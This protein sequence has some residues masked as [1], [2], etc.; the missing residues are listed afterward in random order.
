MAQYRAIFNNAYFK[1]LATATV[2]TL[3]LAAG[4]AQAATATPTLAETL[5]NTTAKAPAGDF[6]LSTTETISG[7]GGYMG[8]LTIAS[9]GS[10]SFDGSTTANTGHIHASGT[11][12]V[13]EG[14][15]LTVK[16]NSTSN[17]DHG[18]F[19]SYIDAGAGVFDDYPNSKFVVN[20]GTVINEHAQIQMNR[21]EL[22][23]AIVTVKTNCGNDSNSD[24]A[25]NAMIGAALA[26]DKAGNLISGTGVLNVT[27][28]SNITLD[29]GSQLFANVF[30]LTGGTINMK[31]ES[32]TNSAVIRGF[33]KGAQINIKGLDINAS[34]SGNYIGGNV[35]NLQ[36][37]DTQVSVEGNSELHLSG[38]INNAVNLES[39]LGLGTVNLDGAKISIAKGGNLVF[40]NEGTVFNANTG[41]ITNS[42]AMTFNNKTVNTTATLFDQ[43]VA[44][45]V[46]FTA[47]GSELNVSGNLD[48]N[49]NK[50][51][52][53]NGAL[54]AEKLVISG[55]KLTLNGDKVTLGTKYAADKLDINAKD[56]VVGTNFVQNRQT[57][58]VA[59][60]LAGSGSFTVSGIAA[61]AVLELQEGG[62]VSGINA[63]TVQGAD[64][65]KTGTLNVTGAWTGL[66]GAKLTL[67]SSGSANLKNASITLKDLEVNSAGL[68]SL[69]GS[70]L[71][72]KES[73]KN[74]VATTAAT[75]G[76]NA[77]NNSS[78]SVAYAKVTS[79]GAA[80]TTNIKNFK[81]DGTSKL[82]LT[83]A[84]DPADKL[85][86]TKVNELKNSFLGSDG[87]GLFQVEGFQATDK[88]LG[89]TDG[90]V[91]YTEASNNAGLA[92]AYSD[93]TVT[94]VDTTTAIASSND[95]G[96]AQ[97]KSGQ[98]SLNIGENGT[99]T[100]S[101]VNGKL[102]T[103]ASGAAASVR[104]DNANATL[105]IQG[106][107]TID[108]IAASGDN[109]GKVL[110]G[111]ALIVNK[112]VGESDSAKIAELNIQQNGSIQAKN[113]HVAVL[114]L[115]KGASLTLAGAETDGALSLSGASVVNGT[116]SAK[117]IT[118]ASG[119]LAIGGSIQATE[120]VKAADNVSI[121]GS[122]VADKLELTQASKNVFVGDE[123]SSG[124]LEVKNLVLNN[125]NL[126]LDPEYTQPTNF[127]AVTGE[128]INADEVISLG[129]NVGVGR[130]S[131]LAIGTSVDAAKNIVSR[132]GLQNG[133]AL[134]EAKGAVLVIDNTL[135]VDSGTA[136]VV[137]SKLDH[138]GLSAQITADKGASTSG[139]FVL[140]KDSVLV[141]TEGM[142]NYSSNAQKPVIEFKGNPTS[143]AKLTLEAGSTL[144]FDTALTAKDEVK[145]TNI[146]GAG[147]VVTTGATIQ[148]ANGL[149]TGAVDSATG[150][151]SF[152][153]KRDQAAK[154][155]YNTSA[156]VKDFVLDA[157][158]GKFG[159]ADDADAGIYYTLMNAGHD[160]GKAVE[161]TARL[162][163]YGGVVQGTDLA[164]KAANDAVVERMSR[165]NPN[166]SLV[167]A[168][169][170]QGGG[171]WLSPVY[172]SH[173][174]DSFD[175]D[176]VDYGVDG[177]LTGLVLGADSTTDS[178]VRVGGYFNFGSASFDGQGVGDQVSNDADYFGFGLYAGMTSGQF[179]L[180]ADAGFTQ[181][182]NDIEQSTGHK[183][184]S[185]VKADVDSTAVTLGLRGE[186]KLNVASVDV[187]P[188]LG[189]RYTRLNID[190]YDAKANGHTLATT[191][192]DTMQMF[193]IPFGVTV[194]KDI[195]AG[196][197]SIKPVFDLTL[198]ANAGDTDA[199]F[200]TT[201]IGGRSLD[202]TS[203]AF[204]SF[205]YGATVGIDAKYG[206][207]FS[208]GLNTNYV[209]SSNADEFGVMGNVRY[210]F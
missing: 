72:V 164:Q 102:V 26:G 179:S 19:G 8:N 46:E 12:E 123:D 80:D 93:V 98:D 191:D 182:S 199:T 74:A 36:G 122:L 47:N 153:L 188:H 193:S 100:L 117:N 180:L 85:D 132:L 81:F 43:M 35:I 55:D 2:A 142:T 119:T 34:G 183:N 175:A 155:L 195:A 208:I 162:A 108:S 177:D 125:G 209:G 60:S 203:E 66:E 192:F 32:A 133:Q 114:K 4:Q 45:K 18:I 88:E 144:A 5:K 158:D 41:T 62:T 147:A 198:T 37:A 194:S 57:L 127:A 67:E 181:V 107:G 149:L 163:V 61:P 185:K 161:G 13:Q 48:L 204:D 110:V 83:G 201:F 207:N 99:V 105:N 94:D 210:M 96:A 115:D 97:L 186:Y 31:G 86:L 10:L 159:K 152:A 118:S 111:D 84:V 143:N 44:G 56:L 131:V 145:L 11:V 148:A 187:T 166:G 130:N 21:I 29:S 150:N 82:V 7:A 24:W 75:A 90:K 64:G 30:N 140:A 129:G 176:G 42:G 157:L 190:G 174:S 196:A 59:D 77:I 113:A 171:L 146:S 52:D 136:V 200:N 92:D 137:N 50:V 156:P 120:T 112:N 89:I 79:G 169:N 139:S 128:D 202:L 103:D 33:Y 178:G 20:G 23:N 65:T 165:S 197:W 38:N 49:T 101:G 141:V 68:L 167:F 135:Q 126:L 104:L 124:L 87:Q 172:K 27:G 151:V 39:G 70:S 95:W 14:G 54:T 58:T 63:I 121:G 206:E 205:T 53:T 173:E 109:L 116:L 51:L 134:Q 69:D 160:G 78:I 71:T 3:A 6:T 17:T 154:G 9:G 16:G 106:Q 28:T 138:A 25:D 73:V 189:V 40:E 76:V 91:S 1:G 170:A 168:N 15:S 184:F 22:N